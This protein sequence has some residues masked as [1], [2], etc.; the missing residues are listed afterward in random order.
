MVSPKRANKPDERDCP[1][2]ANPPFHDGDGRR[3][4][5]EEKMELPD[6]QFIW[7]CPACK[8]IEVIW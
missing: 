2:C 8:N 5:M 6:G 3:V 1:K 7:Q 4:R